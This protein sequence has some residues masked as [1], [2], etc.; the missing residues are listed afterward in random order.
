MFTRSQ[1]EAVGFIIP[2]KLAE[3]WQ[4]DE[5]GSLTTLFEFEAS[6]GNA[7][8]LFARLGMAEDLR[9]LCVGAMGRAH[10]ALPRAQADV[11]S[12]HL[13]AV[14]IP[15]AQG[16][17]DQGDAQLDLLSTPLDEVRLRHAAIRATA[18]ARAALAAVDVSYNVE[19]DKQELDRQKADMA[20]LGYDVP[21]MGCGAA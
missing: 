16:F 3:S 19:A 18:L 2:A 11:E 7:I 21:R 14:A 17:L 13:V 9:S 8:W 20:L 1:L 15:T 6:I 4:G 5:G 10:A 12:G